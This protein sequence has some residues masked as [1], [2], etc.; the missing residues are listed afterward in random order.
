MKPSLRVSVLTVNHLF[1]RRSDFAT[2]YLNNQVF[3]T[4]VN[5]VKPYIDDCFEEKF[6]QT[7]IK[8]GLQYLKNKI[9]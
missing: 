6:S 1:S 7:Q 5:L 8:V 2:Y 4:S 9:V 3:S